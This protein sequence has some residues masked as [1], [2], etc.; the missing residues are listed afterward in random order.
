MLQ[1]LPQESANSM[2]DSST[3]Y[4]KKK[5]VESKVILD[6]L[7]APLF[8]QMEKGNHQRT[9]HYKTVVQNKFITKTTNCMRCNQS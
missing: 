2:P 3:R 8:I 5:W 9:R 7:T 4:L 1:P 6:P